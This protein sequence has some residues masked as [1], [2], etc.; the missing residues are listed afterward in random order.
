MRKEK[1]ETGLQYYI[2]IGVLSTN[3]LIYHYI[4]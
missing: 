4:T 1:K 3:N 2:R